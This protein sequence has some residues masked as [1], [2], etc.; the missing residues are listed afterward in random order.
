M[1]ARAR[2]LAH[3]APL[4]ADHL[5]GDRFFVADH[6]HDIAILPQVAHLLPKYRRI[7]PRRIV[8]PRDEARI[9]FAVAEVLDVARLGIALP[10]L[11]ARAAIAERVRDP[12]HQARLLI[13]EDLLQLCGESAIGMLRGAAATDRAAPLA[14]AEARDRAR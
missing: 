3:R 2:P 13:G 6:Q 10:A 8:G 4:H 14:I 1:L 12:D 7:D 11:R 9:E 5:G